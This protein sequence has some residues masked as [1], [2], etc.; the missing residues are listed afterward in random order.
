[1]IEEAYRRGA[2]FDA[3]SEYYNAKIWENAFA[4]CGIDP[5]FYTHRERN[6]EELL[7]WDFIDCGVTKAFL[8]REWERARAEQTTPDC[9]RA[10][11]GCGAAR[12]GTGICRRKEV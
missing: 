5:A 12:Y 1:M 7:P 10:C 6:V 8:L 3:W 11:S 4:A 9:R 2:H